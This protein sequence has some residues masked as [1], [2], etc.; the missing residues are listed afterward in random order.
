MTIIAQL[1]ARTLNTPC[2][3][4][5][6]TTDLYPDEPGTQLEC[7]ATERARDGTERVLPTCDMLTADRPDPGTPLPCWGGA[8][9]GPDCQHSVVFEYDGNPTG[10]V[11][12]RCVGT[13]E[14]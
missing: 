4:G 13:C 14:L 11:E 2:L 3:R 8:D 5:V 10:S 9:Y 12:V 7:A 1:F 6:D